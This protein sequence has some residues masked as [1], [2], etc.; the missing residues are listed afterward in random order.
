MP[1]IKICSVNIGRKRSFDMGNRVSETGIFKLRQPDAVKVSTLGLVGDV[2]CDARYHGGPDQA[3][4]IYRQEDYLWW[5]NELGKTLESGIFGENLTIEGIE[6]A[7][8][9][10]GDRLQFDELVLE[11][12]APRIPCGLFARRV[13]DPGFVKK[14]LQA[15]RPGFYC[16]VISEGQIAEG[17]TGMLVP[18]TLESISTVEFS[19]DVGQKLSIEKIQRY[20]DLPIDMRSREGFEKKLNSLRSG[21]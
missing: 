11:I 18:T 10:I 1:M 21:K 6:G 5:E 8:L 7:G 9:Y 4:Y 16:R 3:V 20:L 19:S 13:E 12:T 17:N 14:F 15:G 2:I